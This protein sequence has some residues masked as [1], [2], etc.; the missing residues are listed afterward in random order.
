MA[1]IYMVRH[2]EAAAGWNEDPDPGLSESGRGQ[3]VAVA[4]RLAPSGPLNILSSPLKRCRETAAPLAEIWGRGVRVETRV[5]EIPSPDEP[6]ID[7]RAWLRDVQ[8]GTW[9]E[10]EDWLA[11]W[12]QRVIDCL[13]GLRRDSVVFSHFV[14]LNVAVGAARGEDRVSQFRPAHCSVCRFDNAD[15]QL[16]LIALGAERSTVVL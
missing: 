14:A 16:S 11:S 7:R 4:K 13:I 12:R 5:R 10:A 3:A 8:A 2:G 6:N 15:G 9:S 1:T